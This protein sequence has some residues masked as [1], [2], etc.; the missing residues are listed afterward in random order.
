MN[1]LALILDKFLK[2]FAYLLRRDIL[3]LADAPDRSLFDF[4][5]RQ[6]ER[7]GCEYF[8]LG[9]H[10]IVSPLEISSTAETNMGNSGNHR[11]D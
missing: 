11:L 10:L 6:H 4:E 3:I 7:Q 8:G 9:L 1:Y 2:S 5:R